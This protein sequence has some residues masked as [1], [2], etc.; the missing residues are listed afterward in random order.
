MVDKLRLRI[1]CSRIAQRL[2]GRKVEIAKSWADT[3]AAYTDMVEFLDWFDRTSSVEETVR[4]AEADWRHRFATGDVYSGIPHRVAMEIGFGGGRLLMWAARDFERVIGVDIHANFAL[5]KQFLR[6]QGVQNFELIQRDELARVP[7]GSVDFVYSFIV[8]QHFETLDEVEFYLNH[9]NRV[10]SGDGIAQIYYGKKS[11]HGVE[12]VSAED[13][14]LRDCSLFIAPET[15]R[16]IV[17][18]Q[19]EILSYRDA[20]PRDPVAMTGESVQAMVVF[21]RRRSA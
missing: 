16:D 13:F 18:K 5:S 4:R 9:I 6:S 7:D 15:M 19:F 11:G 12:N 20:L 14:R 8:F 10:L 17:A 3:P 2:F 1:L 21:R